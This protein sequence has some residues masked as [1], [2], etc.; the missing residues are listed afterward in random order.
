MTMKMMIGVLILGGSAC[1]AD[2]LLLQ[3]T[4]NTADS[5]DI[6]ADLAG[7]QSG[8][9][10]TSTWT[11]NAGNNWTTQI[12]DNALRLYRSA[13]AGGS[14]LATLAADFAPI[15]TDVRIAVQVKNM[16]TSDGFSMIN[17]GMA[18][19]D[20]FSANAG[21]SF[22]LDARYAVKKLNFFDNGTSVASMDVTSLLSGGLESLSVDFYGG[23]TL[24]ATLNGTAY[25]FGSGQTSYAGTSEAE[26]HIMLGWY[27]DGSPS[28][29]SAKFDNLAIT[30]IPEPATLGMVLSAS[31][32]LLFIRRMIAR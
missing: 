28:L 10:A 24:S 17:F 22:R 4:F 25:D 5:Q 23:N 15:A 8:T 2:I 31:L 19:S 9:G 30:A 29:T 7:R 12:E 3:D 1:F 6:T 11:D 16:N 18:T 21:Y 27:G 13:T 26:N 20:G 32:G 14:V